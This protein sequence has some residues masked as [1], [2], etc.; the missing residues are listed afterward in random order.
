MRCCFI[1]SILSD[2]RARADTFGGALTLSR[3]AAVKTGTTD[4]YRDALTIGYTPS[5]VVGAWVGNND[6]TP[7][8][9]VAGSLGAAPIW[10]QIMEYFLRGTTVE[11]FRKPAPIIQQLVCAQNIQP[12]QT[13]GDENTTQTATPSAYMEYFLPGT[14]PSQPCE[15]TTPTPSGEPSGTPTPT[16]E[17]E[18]TPTPTPTPT[19]APTP[20]PTQAPTPTP[21]VIEV[22]GAGGPPGQEE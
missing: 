1:S 22:P 6:R 8:D 4:D 14:A 19:S 21:I 16:D 9:S 11:Q 5:L 3:P 7:M 17:P 13:E 10:R 18:D 12:T 2:N 20:T 15:V